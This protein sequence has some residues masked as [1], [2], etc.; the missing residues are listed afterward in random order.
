[1]V[2][3]FQPDTF[4]AQVAIIHGDKHVV[5]L[6][7]ISKVVPQARAANLLWTF[8]S[9]KPAFTGEV[10]IEYKIT[11]ADTGE[12]LWAGAD[13]RVGG[14]KLFEKN[15]FDSWGDVQNAFIY[16]ADLAA[17]RLCGIEEDPNCVKPPGG[18]P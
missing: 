2:D 13:R 17:F 14:Q 8:A 3:S 4:R 16:W 12:L 5:G 11:D 7:F 10:S 6:S 1:M 15:V 18:L 9:G